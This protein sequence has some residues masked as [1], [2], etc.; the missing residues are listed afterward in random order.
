MPAAKVA[1]QDT[2]CSPRTAKYERAA[3]ALR[4]GIFDGTYPVGARLPSIRRLSANLQLSPPTALRA[5]RALAEEGLVVSYAGPK[6]TIVV[7]DEPPER[8]RPTTIACLLR[9]HRPRNEAD[10]F[11]LDMIQG[12]REEIS[13]HRYRF[14]YHCLDEEDYLSRM[15]ALVREPWV[16][17][18]L[19]DQRVPLSAIRRLAE[20][21]LPMAL[22]NRFV[23]APRL[24][25]VAPDYE[26]VA[27]ESARLLLDKG[28]RRLGFASIETRERLLTAEQLETSY[29]DLSMRKAFRAAASARGLG[30]ND[31]VWI[32]ET[33]A[34]LQATPEFFGLPRHRPSDWSPLGIFANTDTRAVAL[35]SAIENTDLRLGLDIGVIG[36][37]DLDA[38]RRSSRPPS[39]W[40]I[41]PPAVG[42]GA[43]AQLLACVEDG[44]SPPVW[45]KTPVEFVDRGTF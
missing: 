38:G 17:G 7:R 24:S 28:Y 19:L 21:G 10:N 2:N 20:A 32:E 44:E 39:T 29:P 15:A 30:E 8:V 18:I 45:V 35:L 23:A 1:D 4:Q 22:M 27:R 37:Y 16:C 11:A 42:R 41:D 6:G 13:A 40:R 36:C 31:L 12:M 33:S 26:R 9:P 3:A 25:C 43:A 5:V 34:P 14:V